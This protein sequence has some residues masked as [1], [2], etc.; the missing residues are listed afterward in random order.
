MD[1]VQIQQPFLDILAEPKQSA[2]LAIGNCL[3][4]E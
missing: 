4:M 3:R 1:A 2:M